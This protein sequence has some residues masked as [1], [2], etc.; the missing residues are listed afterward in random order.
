MTGEVKHDYL[1]SIC[2]HVAFVSLCLHTLTHTHKNGSNQIKLNSL[3]CRPP[4]LWMSSHL[5]RR[6]SRKTR[7]L[8]RVSVRQSVYLL[9][10]PRISRCVFSRRT[11]VKP[12][13]SVRRAS[14]A[15]KHFSLRHGGV[16][17]ITLAA[18]DTTFRISGRRLGVFLVGVEGGG[19]GVRWEAG[20]ARLCF[21]QHFQRFT[22]N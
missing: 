8:S 20:D 13:T 21:S 3:P 6:H 22:G 4:D 12:S 16:A 19:V 18:A 2:L 15:R 1:T 9:S 14:C 7:L 17:V 5:Q 11:T 10:P